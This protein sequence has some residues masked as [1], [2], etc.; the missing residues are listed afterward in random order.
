MRYL[1]D[2]VRVYPGVLAADACAELI[3]GFEDRVG[4]QLIHTNDG[5]RFAELNITQHWHEAHELAFAAL[6]PWFEQYT[7]DLGIDSRQ[8]PAELAFEELR[9]KRYRP[10]GDEFTDH[11]DVMDHSSARRF[12]AALLYL[13]DVDEGGETE[14]PLWGQSIIPRAGSLLLFPPLWPWL[15]AGRPPVSKPKHIL[16]TYLHY[17]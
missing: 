15:H 17:V 7:R 5:F 10:G 14:F 4:Q 16:S 1:A 8:W 13:N 6:L 11:V 12:V 9:I 2:L 3:D